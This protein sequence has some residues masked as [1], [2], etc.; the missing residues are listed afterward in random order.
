VRPSNDGKLSVH[1]TVLIRRA[2]LSLLRCLVISAGIHADDIPINALKT[3]S[4]LLLT[5]LDKGSSGTDTVY[6]SILLFRV[7]KFLYWILKSRIAQ[8][9]I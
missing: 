2:T 9:N 6:I 5:I 8:F 7:E 4:G 1:P 3:V